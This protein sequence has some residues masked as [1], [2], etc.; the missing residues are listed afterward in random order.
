MQTTPLEEYPGL[1]T[2][3]GVPKLYFK[4]EDLHKYGS[5]KG[6]SIPLMIDH[7]RKLRISKFAISSSGNAALSAVRHIKKINKEIKHKVSLDIFVGRGI[8]EE[9]HETLRAECTDDTT[10]IKQVVRPLQAL[11]IATKDGS[12][13]SLRQS[14]DDTALIGYRALAKEIAEVE[15]LDAIFIPTSSGTTAVGIT[16]FFEKTPVHIHI[17]QTSMTHPIS[18]VFDINIEESTS[19]ADAIVDRVAHRK[20]ALISLLE[21]GQGFGWTISNNEIKDIYSLVK[22]STGVSL[23][24]NSLLSVAGVKRAI[25]HGEVFNGSIV[26]L[27]TGM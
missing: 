20:D 4:R 1:A 7:Y 26:C 5:H 3:L 14:I 24:Y 15:N 16:D 27:I 23:S 13:Q 10:T 21:S 9:K 6:R 12:A 17:V 19:L 11:H 18:Q 22:K 25:S 2:L 8:T